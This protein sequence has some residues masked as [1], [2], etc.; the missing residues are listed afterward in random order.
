MKQEDGTYKSISVVKDGYVQNPGV[1]YMLSTY[2][3]SPKI[4]NKLIDEGNIDSLTMPDPSKDGCG[5]QLVTMHSTKELIEYCQNKSSDYLYVFEDNKWYWS[6]INYEEVLKELTTADTIEYIDRNSIDVPTYCSFKTA[7]S[8]GG[9][10]IVLLNNIREIDEEFYPEESFL[11]RYNSEND[12]DIFDDTLPCGCCSCCGCSCDGDGDM[13]DYDDDDYY[14]T[15]NEPE[16]PEI[17]QYYI[18]DLSDDDVEWRRKVF[19]DIV[20]HFSEKL[21]S[22]IL[23]VTHYGTSWDYVSTQ[24]IGRLSIDKKEFDRFNKN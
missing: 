6:Y 7:I 24:Y 10:N 15:D 13:D 9:A 12:D 19:P 16:L 5:R 14:D 1:G 17:F 8:W 21:D 2:Y 23:C 22:W 18:T 20:Y 3:Y 4:I 11:E